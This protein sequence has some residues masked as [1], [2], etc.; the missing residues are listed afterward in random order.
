MA[1]SRDV[2]RA[3]V[4]ATGRVRRDLD[5]TSASRRETN[6]PAATGLGLARLVARQHDRQRPGVTNG[7]RAMDPR[8][9]VARLTLPTEGTPGAAAGVGGAAEPRE[10][11][12]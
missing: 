8:C 10:V 1:W 4:G 11:T 6:C 5:P 2:A 12:A 9:G 7:D 3:T